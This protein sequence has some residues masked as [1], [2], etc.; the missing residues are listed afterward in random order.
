MDFKSNAFL[1]TIINLEAFLCPDLECKQHLHDWLHAAVVT[2]MCWREPGKRAR[3]SPKSVTDVNFLVMIV[4]RH[5]D[6]IH[7][8]RKT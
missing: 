6:L 4:S 5:F 7:G 3:L 1:K 8:G 2:S